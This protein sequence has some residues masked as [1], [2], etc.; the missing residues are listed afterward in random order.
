MNQSPIG[1]DNPAYKT[2]LNW[3]RECTT[4]KPKKGD[5]NPCVFPFKPFL[6]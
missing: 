1:E 6:F 3:P 2:H 5:E 4:Y